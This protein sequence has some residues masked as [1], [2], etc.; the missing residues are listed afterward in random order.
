MTTTSVTSGSSWL[1]R[2]LTPAAIDIW[3][4]PLAGYLIAL[5]IA[6]L[7]Q[8]GWMVALLVNTSPPVFLV[9]LLP[10][11]GLLLVIYRLLPVA[12]PLVFVAGAVVPALFA[13]GSALSVL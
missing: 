3:L 13:Y 10:L 6:W 11:V 1:W 2:P 12:R 7:F 5:G 9:T 4:G 8:G